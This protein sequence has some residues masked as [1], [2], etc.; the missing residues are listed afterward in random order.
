[1]TNAD[2]PILTD[3]K[4]LLR[5]LEK[6]DPEARERA[7][8]SSFEPT[9]N[10]LNLQKAVREEV[11]A[12]H[13]SSDGLL[14]LHTRSRDLPSDPGQSAEL[15]VIFKPSLPVAS[16]PEKETGGLRVVV[17]ASVTAAIVSALATGLTVYWLD[18]GAGKLGLIDPTQVAV[19]QQR[20]PAHDQAKPAAKAADQSLPAAQTSDVATAGA[21]AR[22]DEPPVPAEQLAQPVA[23]TADPV[24]ARAVTRKNETRTSFL[25]GALPE[26]ATQVDAAVSELALPEPRLA[27]GPQARERS[28]ATS[29]RPMS[30]PAARFADAATSAATIG[31]VKILSAANELAATLSST[32]AIAS[33][34]IELANL[35]T[36]ETA[37]GPRAATA[38]DATQ[39]FDIVRLNNAGSTAANPENTA[40]IV[41]AYEVPENALHPRDDHRDEPEKDSGDQDAT[42]D[43]PIAATEPIPVTEDPPTKPLEVALIHPK[44]VG[45]P[46]DKSV[47]FPVKVA[48]NAEELAGHYLIIAGL[49]RGARMSSG[50]ELMFDTWH[51]DVSQ[52]AD[53]QLIVPAGFARR[54]H[55][56]I[57]LRRADGTTRKKSKMVLTTPGAA[58]IVAD[59]ADDA[60]DLPAE[61]RR[62]VDEGE[63]QIDN[64]S[65]QGARILFERAADK[66]SARAALMLAGSYDPR[67]VAAY[68]T[69]TP[70]A[71]D[72][73]KARRLVSARN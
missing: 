4:K 34:N 2:D 58:A 61:V 32:G 72:A 25:E 5:R 37:D 11:K 60:V 38:I 68:K 8:S 42:P 73:D 51:I 14:R 65:L 33:E 17:I 12:G 69:V 27:A 30:E 71:P 29:G 40:P 39:G 20:Q 66:G 6:I 67:V 59:D 43:S 70:P 36:T 18:G 7:R 15:P 64:G 41:A 10:A 62:T 57:E 35:N 28:L 21:L 24:A 49:K 23:R 46:V 55:V 31:S 9:I 53:L 44:E 50:I 45:I 22:T 56:D 1:M 13:A 63:V 3:L 54:Q 47:Q 52:L 26:T 16:E 19:W 48:G